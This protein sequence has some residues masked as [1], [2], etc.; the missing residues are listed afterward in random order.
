LDQNRARAFYE[1]TLGFELVTDRT[2]N[3]WRW[4]SLLPPGGFCAIGLVSAPSE[5]VAYPYRSLT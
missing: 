5:L 3:H 4:I 1:N 2:V